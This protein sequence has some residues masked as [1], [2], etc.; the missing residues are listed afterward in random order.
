MVP[1][2]S[3]LRDELATAPHPDSNAAANAQARVN[4]ILRPAGA[5]A[6]LDDLAVWLAGWQNTAMPMIERPIAVI[7]A[8]DH[9]VLAEGVSAYPGDVTQAML[10][11]FN[12]QKGSI[13]AL[14]R[15]A[16]AE[17]QAIDVG[18]GQPTGNIRI[19]PAMD[20]DR[21]AACFAVGRLTVDSL[22][23]DLLILGEMGIGN[24]TSA[25]ALT[26]HYLGVKAS[27]VTGPGSGIDAEELAVKQ[28]VVADAV[29][30][31]GTLTDPLDALRELGGCEIVAMAG[32][33]FEARLRSI[34]VLLDG[35]IVGSA[36]LA[37]HAIDPTATANHW[38]GHCS[39]EPGHRMILDHLGLEP[40]L[41]LDLRLG[42]A[43]GAMAALPLAKAACALLTE[44]PTFEEWF[45]PAPD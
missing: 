5:T 24:T 30:R 25:A 17:V 13:N 31:A 6:R 33:M 35:F 1:T 14:A 42:E 41:T 23:T 37:V 34:P 18:V 27:E 8:G 20:A 7:F 16:G 10:A 21:L 22:D 43:S 36:A 15:I 3:R 44:V 40:L 9:G 4:Q 26:S 11:A 19:E 45:G 32:A 2:T 29:T 38:A 39:A 28:Q 12:Q